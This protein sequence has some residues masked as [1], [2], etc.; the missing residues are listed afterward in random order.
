[1]ITAAAPNMPSVNTTA[2]VTHHRVK[3]TLSPLRQFLACSFVTESH[4]QYAR[5][6][7]RRGDCR[8]GKISAGIM[9]IVFE[10]T[11]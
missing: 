5:T 8:H 11:H 7:K 9:V 1:M 3:P 6:R 4:L 10:G 2:I